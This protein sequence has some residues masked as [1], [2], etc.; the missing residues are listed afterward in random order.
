MSSAAAAL[1]ASALR[2]ADESARVTRLFFA[3]NGERI[4]ECARMMAAAFD[5]GGRL[6]TMGNGGSACDAEHAAVEFVHPVVEKRP[7]LPATALAHATALVTAVGNDEDFTLVFGEQLRVFGRRGDLVLGISTSGQSSNV[8]RGLV[9]ARELGI[10]TIGLAGKD[11]GRMSTLTDFFFRV[12][13]FNVHR[14]QEAQETLLH[15]LWDLV[16]V[17]RGEEDVLG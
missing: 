1:R 5:A 8:N 6:F 2:K 7:A 14:I 16:H 12:P 13:S 10:H 9:V 15:V 3:E 11:G 17:I 4:V